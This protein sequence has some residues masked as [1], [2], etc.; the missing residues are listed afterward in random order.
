MPDEL[1]TLAE[2]VSAL[3]RAVALLQARTLPQPPDWIKA[4]AVSDEE[5]LEEVSRLG[6][7]FRKT[8]RISDGPDD[9]P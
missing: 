4:W 1:K 5:A 6:R 8:G 3:E 7:E 9:L 2:R